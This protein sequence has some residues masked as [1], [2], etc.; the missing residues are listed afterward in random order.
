MKPI[1]YLVGDATR[2]EVGGN[3]II[4]HICNDAGGWGKGFVLAL[5]QVSPIPESSY[6]EWFARRWGL[7]ILPSVPSGAFRSH[8]KFSSPT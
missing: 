2:P 5:S 1:T 6:R 3:K 4:A 8:P 7:M